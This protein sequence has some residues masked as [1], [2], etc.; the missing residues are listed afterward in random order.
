ME[1]KVLKD[2][3]VFDLDGTIVIDNKK[4]NDNIIEKLEQLMREGHMVI[5]ATSRSIRG[6]KAVLPE[7]FFSNILLLCNGAFAI[8][9]EQILLSNYIEEEACIDLCNFLNANQVQYYL[10]LGNAFYVP[11]YVSHPFIDMLKT[12]GKGEQVYT[13]LDD[14]SSRVYKVAILDIVNTVLLKKLNEFCG[15]VQYFVHSDNTVDVVADNCSKW[16]MLKKLISTEEIVYNR[17]IAFGNDSNDI[18]LIKNADIGVEVKSNNAEL[19]KV[20]DFSITDY[21]SE[22]IISTI[23]KTMSV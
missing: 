18:E 17:I 20:A 23:D 16:E 22:S 8:E 14:I 2:I 15:N 1:V 7:K 13:K 19:E 9:K 6:V 11:E 3:F 12:E 10:E 4:I 5:F 21:Y